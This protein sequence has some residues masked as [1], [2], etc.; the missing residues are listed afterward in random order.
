MSDGVLVS[1][2]CPGEA[3]KSDTFNTRRLEAD[4]SSLAA[5]LA[6]EWEKAPRRARPG[7]ARVLLLLA[8]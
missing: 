6:P 8:G 5:K 4:K 2:I 7:S 1:G 3:Q